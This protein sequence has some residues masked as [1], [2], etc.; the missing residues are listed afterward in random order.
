MYIVLPDAYH[1]KGIDMSNAWKVKV[2]DRPV[3]RCCMWWTALWAALGGAQGQKTGWH[4]GQKQPGPC[5]GD[6]IVPGIVGVVPAEHTRSKVCP[7]A[8]VGPC[9]CCLMLKQSSSDKKSTARKQLLESTW[10]LKSP[11]MIVARDIGQTEASS[12]ES[13]SRKQVEAFR[14]R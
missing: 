3:D 8:C 14:R 4:G 1:L 5:N 2:K 10:M 7:L 13:S 11:T 6:G 12:S 9:T